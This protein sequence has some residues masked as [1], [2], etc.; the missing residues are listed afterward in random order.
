MPN[1]NYWEEGKPIVSAVQYIGSGSNT[2]AEAFLQTVPE[3]RASMFSTNPE[4][5][6]GSDDYGYVN[7]PVALTFALLDCDDHWSVE[8]TFK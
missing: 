5:I 8:G 1:G 6:T 7:T 2:N 4:S 3:D